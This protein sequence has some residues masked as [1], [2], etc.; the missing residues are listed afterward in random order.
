MNIQFSFLHSFPQ[1]VTDVG[2]FNLAEY[3][4]MTTTAI[5]EALFGHFFLCKVQLTLD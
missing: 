3:F 5:F 2:L 1:I 4:H